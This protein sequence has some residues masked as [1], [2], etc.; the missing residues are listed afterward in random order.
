MAPSDRPL[1]A[2]G[3]YGVSGWAQR[4]LDEGL[5]AV[6]RS[7]SAHNEG[8]FSMARLLSG[9]AGGTGR[10]EFR[11][12]VGPGCDQGGLHHKGSPRS[13]GQGRQLALLGSRSSTLGSKALSGPA[14]QAIMGGDHGLNVPKGERPA[15]PA[16]APAWP[17]CPAGQALSA[18]C[19][20]ANPQ[21]RQGHRSRPGW[22]AR[23]PQWGVLGARRGRQG[24]D[25]GCV[26]AADSGP[27]RALCAAGIWSPAGGFFADP[28]KWKRNT[29]LAVV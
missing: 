9:Q 2:L 3:A 6:E 21:A 16:C 26:S 20:P 11:I 28:K 5:A 1:T 13:S 27:L 10:E 24:G 17:G 19:G 18:A 8:A 23:G 4:V 14:E 22:R 29:A 15:R 7:D 25:A 12:S